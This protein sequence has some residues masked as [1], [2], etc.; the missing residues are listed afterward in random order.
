MQ[1]AVFIIDVYCYSVTILLD[2]HFL[3]V[4]DIDAC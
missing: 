1:R 4:Y 2:C 3:A